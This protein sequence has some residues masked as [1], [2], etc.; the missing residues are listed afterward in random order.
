M[1]SSW[2]IFHQSHLMFF[3]KQRLHKQLACVFARN[4]ILPPAGLTSNI[5]LA[6]NCDVCTEKTV[7]VLCP[8]ILRSMPSGSSKE[9]DS[10]PSFNTL[11]QDVHS[12]R[13]R[14]RGGRERELCI[15][16]MHERT[17][18]KAPKAMSA[19]QLGMHWPE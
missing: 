6:H 15:K 12:E 1:L 14:E 4:I 3:I 16:T 5:I 19:D 2:L 13:T 10:D 17:H 7:V 18:A 8:F 11:T 9:A